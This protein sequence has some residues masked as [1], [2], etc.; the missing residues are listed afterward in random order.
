MFSFFLKL[1]WQKQT[2]RFDYFSFN[3]NHKITYQNGLEQEVSAAPEF[4]GDEQLINPEEQLGSAL[5]SCHLLSFLFVCSKENIEVKSYTDSV[6]VKLERLQR[7]KMFVST[8]VLSPKVEFEKTISA[9]KHKELHQKAHD[10]CFIA[11]SIKS[12]VII[13]PT[14]KH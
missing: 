1:D 2:E 13:N 7:G 6:E 4:Q 5:M 12:E 8:I 9:L 3:R 14:F 10:V 11:N